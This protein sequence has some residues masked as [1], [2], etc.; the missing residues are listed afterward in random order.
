MPSSRLAIALPRLDAAAVAV[1][2]CVIPAVKE[3]VPDVARDSRLFTWIS[4]PSKPAFS[5]CAPDHARYAAGER[6]GQECVPPVVLIAQRGVAGGADAPETS[7]GRRR[8]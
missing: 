6:I 1:G 7:A 4:R 3:N 2:P 5:V 8:Y